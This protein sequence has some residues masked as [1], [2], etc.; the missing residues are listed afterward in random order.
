MNSIEMVRSGKCTAEQC[1]A[2]FESSWWD[3]LPAKE[4]F[5]AQAR[6]GRLCMPFSE[7]H[8]VTEEALGRSVFTHEFA[9]MGEL[10]EEFE[11]GEG[12]G[13][14]AK[15]ATLLDERRKQG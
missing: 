4:V 11:I 14:M 8:R 13:S 10:L 2:L 1:K 9:L 15:L 12:R 7:F 5:E 3:G 6:G